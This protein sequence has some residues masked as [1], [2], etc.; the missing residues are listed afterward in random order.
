[1]LNRRSFLQKAGAAAAMVPLAGT[2][3]GSKAFGETTAE[4]NT[5]LD[6]LNF[7]LNL[8][9]L[10]SEY[11]LYATTGGGLGQ[12]GVAVTGHGPLGPLTVKASPRVKFT[13]PI[14]EQF[15][16]EIAQDETDHV[17]FLRATLGD[18][19]VA[20]PAIDLLNSFN[21]LAQ[22]AGLG[23]SFDPFASELNFVI[24]G[25]IFEDVGVT[26]YHGA[27]PLI[28]SKGYLA[29][30]A[31]ILAVEAYHASELRTILAYENSEDL[32]AGI[33][34]MV[35]KISKLRET[36]DGT[37]DD[38]QGITIDYQANIVPTD[39]NGLAFARTTRQVLDIVYGKTNASS[40]LFFPD[41]I[42]EYP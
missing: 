36:V 18:N 7:A 10:E 1:M 26:A 20:R 33:A 22:A 28:T 25:F 39:E 40:G 31:G 42:N 8:E 14:L 24:G 35:E 3:L 21:T 9:Y 6:I 5:D 30:A 11:Y 23:E 38:D 32:S 2:L 15:A 4:M 41:G 37:G 13:D 16:N 27:A 12:A 34:G 17:K 19:A 29:A